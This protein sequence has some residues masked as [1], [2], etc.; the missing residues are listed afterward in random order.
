MVKHHA[1][2]AGEEQTTE[3]K[4]AKRRKKARTEK[5]HKRTHLRTQKLIHSIK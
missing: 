3:A 2:P 5:R 4:K 1:K